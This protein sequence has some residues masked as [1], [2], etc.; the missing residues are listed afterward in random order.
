[1]N[2][3]PNNNANIGWRI[4]SRAIRKKFLRSGLGNSLAPWIFRSAATSLALS[5]FWMSLVAF[6][7]SKRNPQEFEDHQEGNG[8][9]AKSHQGRKP[10]VQEQG[11]TEGHKGECG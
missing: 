4:T 11:D 8:R 3:P 2:P 6:I 5:P 7:S 9:K 10:I 1:M